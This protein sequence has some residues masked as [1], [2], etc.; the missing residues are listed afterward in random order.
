M[1]LQ[2]FRSY[3]YDKQIWVTTQDFGT[4]HIG[5]KISQGSVDT[6]YHSLANHP[7]T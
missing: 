5:D 3:V 1:S 6:E 4:Y 7:A 2:G